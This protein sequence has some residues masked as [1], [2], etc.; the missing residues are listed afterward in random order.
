VKIFLIIIS[1]FI[2]GSCSKV[3]KPRTVKLTIASN[4]NAITAKPAID[5]GLILKLVKSTGEIS[6]VDMPAPPY[7]VVLANGD[8][9][10]YA[11]GFTGSA[12]WSG[13][14]YCGQAQAT[15]NGTDA[16]VTINATTPECADLPYSQLIASKN[17]NWD[18]ALWDQSKWGP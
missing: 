10:L 17:N 1:L 9:T 13:T 18:S 3:A 5:G 6:Y 12:A 4:S 16:T 14:T 8:W 15:L 7:D 11:V 2:L